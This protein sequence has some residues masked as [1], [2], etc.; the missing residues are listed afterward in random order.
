MGT[1]AALAVSKQKRA[2]GEVL[3]TVVAVGTKAG[4]QEMADAVAVR[5]PADSKERR[6]QM[7]KWQ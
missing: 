6:V 3:H 2:G 4:T 7:E 5:S 1:E